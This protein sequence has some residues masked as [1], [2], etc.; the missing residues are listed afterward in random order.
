MGELLIWRGNSEEWSQQSEVI[1]YFSFGRK[2]NLL[3]TIANFIIV[4]VND[5]NNNIKHDNIDHAGENIV[6]DQAS[7]LFR[8]EITH[9]VHGIPSIHEASNH[10]M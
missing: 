9:S 10:Q 2:L 6:E 8:I 7:C 4:V 3:L 5:W 1:K